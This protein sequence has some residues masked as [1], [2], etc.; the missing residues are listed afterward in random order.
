MN[1][2]INIRELF[3]QFMKDKNIY[4]QFAKNTNERLDI[5]V[6]KHEKLVLVFI[7]A[8][9]WAN[10]P[11][12]YMFWSK[13]NDEWFNTLVKELTPFLINLL[14][15]YNLYGRFMYNAYY[16]G[17]KFGINLNKLINPLTLIKV[18]NKIVKEETYKARCEWSKFLKDINL[19]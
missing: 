2:K 15:R 8:F 9:N 7:D 19:I 16:T 6:N 10:T 13:L 4:Y 14:K 1:K 17:R 18:E 5:F 3:F 11:E 12:G